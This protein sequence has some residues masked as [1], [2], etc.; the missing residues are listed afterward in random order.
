[1]AG[2]STSYYFTIGNS[3]YTKSTASGKTDWFVGTFFNQEDMDD[4]NDGVSDSNDLCPRTPLNSTVDGNGCAS[5]VAS[6]LTSVAP[7]YDDGSNEWVTSSTWY[8]FTLENATGLKYRTWNNGTWSGWSTTS[9]SSLQLGLVDGTLH[10]EWFAYNGTRVENVTHNRTFEHDASSPTVGLVVGA[11]QNGSVVAPWTDFTVISSDAGVGISLTQYRVW[12]G[13]DWGAWKNDTGS[14]NLSGVAN[15]TTVYIEA[16]AYDH[17]N[18]SS[19]LMN[20]TFVVDDTLNAPVSALSSVSASHTEGNLVTWVQT[21]SV[22]SFT[23]TDATG[24]RYRVWNGSWSAWTNIPSNFSLPSHPDGQIVVEWYATNGSLAESIHNET[25]QF[26]SM[27]PV[28]AVAAGTPSNGTRIAPWTAVRIEALD[29]GVGVDVTTYRTWNGS[30][31][32]SWVGY[33][34][35]FNFSGLTG[36][37]AVYVEAYSVDLLGHTSP[38]MNQSLVVDDTLNAPLSELV[39]VAISHDDGNVIWVTTGSAYRFSLQNAT[40]ISLRVWDGSWSSWTSISNNH[41][42]SVLNDGVIHVEWYAVNGSLVEVVH[43]ASFSF[44]TTSPSLSLIVGTPS[45]GNRIA[46]WTPLSLN[47]SD[48][49]AGVDVLTYRVNNGSGWGSWVNASGSFN[50]SGHG[51]GSIQIQ[52]NATDHLGNQRILNSTVVLDDTFNAPV[53]ALVSISISHSATGTT[54]VTSGSQFNFSLQNATGISYRVWDGAW[55]G[56]SNASNSFS[57]TGLTEGQIR[58]EWYAVNGSETEN[59]HNATYRYDATAPTVEIAVGMPSNGTQIAPHT[60]ITLTTN[61]AGVGVDAMSYRLWN[62][63]AWSS[64]SAHS[65]DFNLSGFP[66]G[67]AFV[68]A[69]STDHLGQSSSTLN[70]S[71]VVD[72]TLNAPVSSLSSISNRYD[73]TDTWVTNSSTLTFALENA[74]GVRIRI[75]DGSWGGWSTIYDNLTLGI[76]N[77]GAIHVEWYAVNGSLEEARHNISLRYDHTLPTIT[78]GVGDPVDGDRI[79]SWTELSLNASDSGVGL[80]QTQYRVHS[81]SIWSTWLNYT[82]PFNL[83][84]VSGDVIIEAVS[85][86]HLGLESMTLN[87][88]LVVDDT[89]NA[90]VSELSSI[91]IWVVDGN[92]TWVTGGSEYNFTLRNATGIHYR[93]WDGTW[94]SW[95]SAGST[96]TISNLSDGRIHVEWYAVNGSLEEDVHNATYLYDATQ[97]LVDLAVGSPSNGTRIAPWTPLNLSANDN[98]VGL[99]FVQYRVWNGTVW[100]AWTNHSGVFNLSGFTAGDHIIEARSEDRLGISSSVLNRS[101]ILDDSFHAP[102]SSLTTHE[103]YFNA[104]G[105]IWLRSDTQLNFTMENATHVSYRLWDGTWSTWSS[106]TQNLTL[107][108][109]NDG[110][111]RIQWQAVNGSLTES[112]HELTFDFDSSPPAVVIEIG[113]PWDGERLASWTPIVLNSTDGGV[114]VDATWVRF[115]AG[116]GWTN[117]TAYSGAFNLSALGN[118]STVTLE[119]YA[120][121][122][123]GHAS[124]I[125]NLTMIVDDTYNAPSSSLVSVE[126]KFIDSGGGVWV[127]ADSQLNLSTENATGIQYRIFDGGWGSWS[128]GTDTI[129]TTGL[130]AGRIHVE[131]RAVNGS[132]LEPIHNETLWYDSIAPTLRLE[133]GE[134]SNGTRVTSYTPLQLIANDTGVGISEVLHRIWNGSGWTA[135][136]NATTDFNLSGLAGVVIIEAY[137]RDH[138]GHNSSMVNQTLV[139]DDS[140][141]SPESELLNIEGTYVDG[142]G[143]TWVTQSS[144][145]NFTLTNATGLRYRVWDGSWSSWGGVVDNL[146]LS[147]ANDGLVHL[148]WYAWNDTLVE[149]ALHNLSVQMDDA[150]PYV[151]VS[152]DFEDNGILAPWSEI[153]VLSGDAGVGVNSTVHRLW[154]GTNWT[155]WTPYMGPFNLSGLANGPY[156]LEVRATDHLGQGSVVTNLSLWM[157]DHFLSPVSQLVSLTPIYVDN[158]SRTW[159][160]QSGQITLGLTNTSWHRHRILQGGGQWSGWVLGN[161]TINLTGVSVGY[162]EVEWQA[163]NGTRLEFVTHNLS[164][165]MDALA[166]TAQILPG[167]PSLGGMLTSGTPISLTATDGNGSGVS[168]I[169][170]RLD[171]GTGWTGWRNY[172]GTFNLSEFAGAFNVDIEVYATD[173]I[174]HDGPIESLTFAIDDSIPGVDLLLAGPEVT[175]LGETVAWVN[176]STVFDLVGHN[177]TQILVRTWDGDSWTTWANYSGSISFAQVLGNVTVVIEYQGI[178]VL[179]ATPVMN[180][181]YHLDPEAPTIG[182][183]VESPRV[184]PW[185]NASTN[186][187]FFW[188]DVGIG[189]DSQMIRWMTVNGWGPWVDYNGSITPQEMTGFSDGDGQLAARGCDRMGSCTYLTLNLSLDTIDPEFHLLVDGHRITDWSFVSYRTP[190]NLSVAEFGSGI[191]VALGRMSNETWSS[192]WISDM[193]VDITNLSIGT[194]TLELYAR[195]VAGNDRSTA[196][197][198]HLVDRIPET[199]IMTTATVLDGVHFFGVNDTINTTCD[200]DPCTRYHRFIISAENVSWSETLG[201]LSPPLDAVRFEAYSIGPGEIPSFVESIALKVDLIAPSSEIILPVP[202]GDPVPYNWPV[203]LRSE[204]P[205]PSGCPILEFTYIVKRPDGSMI[206]PFTSIEEITILLD[207]GGIWEWTV[208]VTDCVGNAAE[209]EITLVEVI[210]GVHRI[211]WSDAPNGTLMSDESSIFEMPLNLTNSG[212][213]DMEIGVQLWIDG[214]LVADQPLQSLIVNE[215]SPES[216]LNFLIPLTRSLS[217]PYRIVI[218]D[219]NSSATWEWN[220][221]MLVRPRPLSHTSLTVDGE[222]ESLGG[223]FFTDD[224]VIHVIG[225]YSDHA[226]SIRVRVLSEAGDVCIDQT[227]VTTS[228]GEFGFW[229]ETHHTSQWDDWTLYENGDEHHWRHYDVCAQYGGVV[230]K[231]ETTAIGVPVGPQLLSSPQTDEVEM[232]YEGQSLTAS[233][234]FAVGAFALTAALAF[235]GRGQEFFVQYTE[236]RLQD[237]RKRK[238]DEEDATP[239]LELRLGMAHSWSAWVAAALMIA[240]ALIISDVGL[241]SIAAGNWSALTLEL[242]ISAL[243]VAVI[244]FLW[245]EAY[246]II[247][248]KIAGLRYGFQLSFLGTVSLLFTALFLQAPFGFPGRNYNEED[249]RETRNISG[250]VSLG[251]L[252]SLLVV[253][254]ALSLC[255]TLGVS[256]LFA[257]LGIML[258]AMFLLFSSIPIRPLDG[259]KV[260]RWNRLVSH[261]FTVLALAIY[262]GVMYRSIPYDWL[263]LLGGAA[264]LGLVTILILF[265]SVNFDRVDHLLIDRT[266]EF[267]GMD[268]TESVDWNIE[269]ESTG[270]EGDLG[271]ETV[272]TEPTAEPTEAELLADAI[273]RAEM[274]E[275]ERDFAWT[276]ADRIQRDRIQKEGEAE[277]T[278]LLEDVPVESLPD[279]TE[280]PAGHDDIASETPVERTSAPIPVI[281]A[282]GLPEGWST[283]QWEYYGAEWLAKQAEREKE[284]VSVVPTTPIVAEDLSSLTVAKLKERLREAGMKV[285]GKKAE[286]IA[287]LEED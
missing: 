75:Y 238:R 183:L 174:G 125:V 135:W 244:V 98:G 237:R 243:L 31:W 255:V 232:E 205:D 186:L 184:L 76:L 130:S 220:G 115:D 29:A 87:R 3:N 257:P 134:P 246:E 47:A 280:L 120:T 252:F 60:P 200:I 273:K 181:S 101:F 26:D 276:E 99:G 210:D 34:G 266:R 73:A 71:Y 178:G 196:I 117:W 122:E 141:N 164:L 10:L 156:L 57:I 277:F 208:D 105:T 9:S 194:Y 22:Y 182:S 148:E 138:L 123:L 36:T 39:S 248:R 80:N 133:I 225:V 219:L 235:F 37:T 192:G 88:S 144:R 218:H 42:L 25:F 65:G 221:T 224:A 92:E 170:Y 188:D 46:P 28:V 96:F 35:S 8:N 165:W 6:T 145:F 242:A 278:S 112:P 23:T 162:F 230:F 190:V 126:P 132:L 55:S 247:L 223:F 256:A 185:V 2:T 21:G 172:S 111:I 97:P 275:K 32:S 12:N 202:G 41:S 129:P 143:T 270:A 15:G 199:S 240:A 207:R 187:T 216:S 78:L 287:R 118:G 59:S 169:S 89:L 161:G 14:F 147:S 261:V 209:T 259:Y 16:M 58:I 206:G 44:D 74:S 146:T 167:S 100:T 24:L 258:A 62:G 168:R 56:W 84:G 173:H 241:A 7:N 226:N 251:K 54:W 50:L 40:G 18:Q 153:T 110:T 250:L 228:P 282:E 285:S 137:S 69:I 33:G 107:G 70:Q 249:E 142:N 64:W 131:W 227:I 154:N 104:S 263:T 268:E 239:H 72:S 1:V 222:V 85:I 193:P 180:A 149:V 274:A 189:L 79:A 49:G 114:G 19:S 195:D 175:R 158:Q 236:E 234:N 121:D 152:I 151:L 91:S 215:S 245:M 160:N 233:R 102:V 103:P 281:P 82:T 203:R 109:L 265:R 67:V 166:P 51:A 95:F 254:G 231:I 267:E 43:N 212:D 94:S 157:D 83:S 81:N 139:V 119:A 63:S 204:D 179:L 269:M 217:I 11:P 159:T 86:D 20:R 38:T 90:P 150:S 163:I 13:T 271:V 201:P 45:D 48:A 211:D 253:I 279:P 106:T 198:L 284:S 213:Y 30:A 155:S 264:L 93:I 197:T 61:D 66:D 124:A 128:S 262:F 283:E 113:T 176:E 17:L 52:S 4:D 171:N 68:E 191:E 286:L 27:A 127:R 260:W 116:S 136:T 214:S 5:V 53:S 229:I 140:Y 77:D 108:G 272:Q 177:T